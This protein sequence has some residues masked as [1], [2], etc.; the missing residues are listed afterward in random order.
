MYFS[1]LIPFLSSTLYMSL[2]IKNQSKRKSMRENICFCVIFFS[3]YLIFFLVLIPF[4]SGTLPVDQSIMIFPFSVSW[5]IF[6]WNLISVRK[7]LE[8]YFARNMF[9]VSIFVKHSLIN[10]QH[11]VDYNF[12]FLA[13]ASGQ[14]SLAALL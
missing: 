12:S 11:C 5:K 3:C 7:I 4:L 1:F 13:F 14:Y 10:R 8:K 9:S 2:S 6:H